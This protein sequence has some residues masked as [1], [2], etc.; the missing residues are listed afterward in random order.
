M[1]IHG[2]I[3]TAQ[4][5]ELPDGGKLTEVRV[6]DKMKPS[7]LRTQGEFSLFLSDKARQDL[8]KGDLCDADVTVVVQSITNG[9]N[10]VP[11]IRGRVLAGIVPVE[12]VPVA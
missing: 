10:G 3:N 4:L 1:I 2:Q 12:K 11:K 5:I 9:K 8:P 6:V 7:G